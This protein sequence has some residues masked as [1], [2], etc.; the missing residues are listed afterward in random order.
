MPELTWT[1]ALFVAVLG[2]EGLQRIVELIVSKKRQGER[3]GDGVKPVREA[4]WYFMVATHALLFIAPPLEVLVFNR[5]FSWSVG[6]PALLMLG[7]A[8]VLR[9]WALSTLGKSW[10]ARVVAPSRVVAEGPYRFIRHPNYL[11]VITELAVIP[12]IHTAFLSA[13]LLSVMNGLVLMA[14]IKTEEE[15]LFSIPGYREAMGNKPR[16]VPGLF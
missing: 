1:H 7:L 4:A 16:F 2:V 10:N 11:V 9:W 8:K 12:L 6:G 13:I 5:P 3:A 15:T 14:R